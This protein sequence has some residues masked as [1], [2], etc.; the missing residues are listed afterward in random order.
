MTPEQ[1]SRINIQFEM[2]RADRRWATEHRTTA[3]PPDRMDWL[4]RAM[5]KHVGAT[6]VLEVE[7]ELANTRG[8]L[9]RLI[10]AVTGRWQPDVE[11]GAQALAAMR[12]LRQ[13]EAFLL[14]L[15]DEQGVA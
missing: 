9:A 8:C 1:A 5:E 7:M 2:V 11:V 10:E 3:I 13:V 6:A 15:S 12:Q 4:I 14:S